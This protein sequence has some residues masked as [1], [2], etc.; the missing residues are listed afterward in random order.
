MLS[1]KDADFL[2]ASYRYLRSVE[3]GLRLMNSRAGNTLPQEPLELAKLAKRQAPPTH[4]H[5]WTSAAN[6]CPATAFSNA[7]WRRRA[8]S[9]F[10]TPSILACHC[11]VARLLARLEELVH[12]F[13]RLSQIFRTGL[14]LAH[15]SAKSV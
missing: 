2:T 13:R 11:F 15:R 14:S 1:A 3:G 7:R 5:C 10:F 4:R 12:R 9:A 6:T 8:S